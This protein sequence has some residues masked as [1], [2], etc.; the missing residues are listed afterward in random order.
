M[1]C[2]TH[3]PHP[4]RKN[5]EYCITDPVQY[6]ILPRLSISL[7]IYLRCDFTLTKDLNSQL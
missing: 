5:L 6:G 7:Q 3:V 2:V 4:N 1:T